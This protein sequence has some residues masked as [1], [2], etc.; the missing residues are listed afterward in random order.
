MNVL[1]ETT[2]RYLMRTTSI[3]DA[4]IKD[5]KDDVAVVYQNFEFDDVEKRN[6]NVQ[7]IELSEYNFNQTDIQMQTFNTVQF[8]NETTFKFINDTKLP[9]PSE[10]SAFETMQTFEEMSQDD[11]QDTNLM[12]FQEFSFNL[13]RD[14]FN[15]VSR[16][17]TMQQD[18]EFTLFGTKTFRDTGNFEAQTKNCTS[19]EM[20][21]SFHDFDESNIQSNLRSD[22]I[23]DYCDEEI[24]SDFENALRNL[25]LSSSTPKK[26]SQSQE[27][28]ESESKQPKL[29][30]DQT[31]QIWTEVN[32]IQTEYK[33]K[34]DNHPT[35]NLHSVINF[36]DSISTNITANPSVIPTQIENNV[37]MFSKSSRKKSML[38]PMTI[39]LRTQKQTPQS[40]SQI[41]KKKSKKTEVEKST[42]IDMNST[43]ANW[44]LLAAQSFNMNR[45]N[46]THQPIPLNTIC[47]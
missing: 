4:T 22:V 39:K 43:D 11:F 35:I 8:P 2:K 38:P 32:P 37:E 45:F 5:E 19:F 15:E 14:P 29:T 21:S 10:L 28:E 25:S 9:P 41:S 7:T 16:A 47:K 46:S 1:S 31:T 24:V 27:I 36:T 26:S 18:N 23:E 12:E 40:S 3:K 17:F 30:E 20:Q 42:Q 13:D 6:E 34:V 44:E 33:I